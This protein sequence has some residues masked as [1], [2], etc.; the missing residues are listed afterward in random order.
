MDNM[1]LA[2]NQKIFFIYNP[3]ALTDVVLD[4]LTITGALGVNYG[5]AIDGFTSSVSIQGSTIAGNVVY[6]GY[7]GGAIYTGAALSVEDS[8]FFGNVAIDGTNATV[9]HGGG[10][11]FSN[12]GYLSARNTT[13]AENQALNGTGGS[14]ASARTP[15]AAMAATTR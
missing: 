8:A 7:G 3:I 4:G 1:R 5:G 12:G 2:D 14:A 6:A 13:F 15:C 9:G 10:A 11:I